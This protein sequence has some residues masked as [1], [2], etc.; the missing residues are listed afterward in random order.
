MKN[1]ILP[2]CL[3]VF[4]HPVFANTDNFQ[5]AYEIA[6]QGS[7]FAQYNLGVRYANGQGIMRNTVLANEWYLKAA[8]NGNAM[9][10]FNIG[11]NYLNGKDGLPKNRGQALIWLQKASENGHT[12]AK[13]MLEGL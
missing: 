1:I 11:Q 5:D 6:Q 4:I 2:L 13:L 12:Q 3:F 9:A 10:Q 8:N 7:A